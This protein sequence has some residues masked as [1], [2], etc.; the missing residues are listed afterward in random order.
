MELKNGMKIESG[1]DEER[2]AVGGREREEA[3]NK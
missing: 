2:R 3:K 1:E